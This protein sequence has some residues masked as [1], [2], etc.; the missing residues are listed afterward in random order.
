MGPKFIGAI[1]YSVVHSDIRITTLYD[2]YFQE[3]III[4]IRKLCT[5]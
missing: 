2:G 3:Y 4:K 5:V 1:R